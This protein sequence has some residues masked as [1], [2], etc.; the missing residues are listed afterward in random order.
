[1][2]TNTP[3]STAPRLLVVDDQP[4]NVQTL[5]QIFRADHEVL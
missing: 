3:L 2:T 4:I 1:M 5:Y